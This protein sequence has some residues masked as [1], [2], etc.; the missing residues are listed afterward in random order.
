MGKNGIR[1]IAGFTYASFLTALRPGGR[2]GAI[3][4][5]AGREGRQRQDPT[6]RVLERPAQLCQTPQD[7]SRH[8]LGCRSR[9]SR[10]L[11]CP[12]ED[13]RTPR[14]LLLELPR[15]PPRH[16]RCRPRSLAPRP[17]PPNTQVSTSARPVAQPIPRHS[18]PAPRPSAQTF[19]P[20][21]TVSSPKSRLGPGEVGDSS[22]G[23]VRP[24][25]CRLPAD[26]ARLTGFAWSARPVREHVRS[27]R[28]CA[29]G[30]R[31]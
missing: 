28:R 26:P 21:A 3:R 9:L 20:L 13:L 12:H 11:P 1:Y 8:P 23:V 14:H 25:T 22:Q 15:R 29:V 31:V 30:V 24:P 4:M 6:I 17:R 19:A 16:P 18:D 10:C 5:E 27:S 2:R 7:L